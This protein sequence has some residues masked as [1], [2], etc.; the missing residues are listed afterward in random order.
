MHEARQSPDKFRSIARLR[1]L[2][3][4][5][6]ST[7]RPN[8]YF[9]QTGNNN[10]NGISIKMRWPKKPP[11]ILCKNYHPYFDPASLLFLLPDAKLSSR[12]SFCELAAET[13]CWRVCFPGAMARTGLCTAAASS[14]WAKTWF[15]AYSSSVL[16]VRTCDCED[17]ALRPKSCRLS[18]LDRLR[19]LAI[20]SKDDPG[21]DET[22]AVAGVGAV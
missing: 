1:G 8:S 20:E 18:D 5:P 22:V 21:F 2:D 4:F 17:T 14:P 19:S 6:D 11:F 16:K 3:I 7:I 13:N 12:A 15:E 10:S 9:V